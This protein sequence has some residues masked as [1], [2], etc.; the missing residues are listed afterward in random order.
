[1]A[2]LNGGLRLRLL[3]R[4]LAVQGSWNYRTLPGAG[5]AF[6]LIPV[7]SRLYR[8]DR[9]ALARSVGR[10]TDFFNSHPYLAGVAIAAL[11]R[12]ELERVEPEQISRFKSVLV[13]PLGTLGDRLIWAHWRP[14]CSFLALLLF[15][16][17]A[18]WWTA[19][20]VFLILYNTVHLWLRLWGL[21]V[22]WREGREVG[23]VLMGSA[24][25]RLPDRLTIPLALVGGALLP[26]IALA[27][28]GGSGAGSVSILAIAV[29]LAAVGFWRSALAGRAAVAALVLGSVA[30]AALGRV[31]W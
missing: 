19:L 15:T 23:R 3:L 29:S 28:G 10:H 14:L 6:S 7:L 25:R 20:A 18:P 11:A 13:G 17:G 26:P 12:L 4:S 2:E 21:Q 5:L 31:V 30:F 1:M 16:A 22:G 27:V 9:E 8:G 24:L